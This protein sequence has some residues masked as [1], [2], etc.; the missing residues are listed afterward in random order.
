MQ[1]FRRKDLKR[2]R[3]VEEVG[4][5]VEYFS[6]H[7]KQFVGGGIAALVLLVG[8]VGY[9][10]YARQRGIDS[11]AALLKATTLY[12]G[13]V[14][15]ETVPGVTT[16][17]TEAER[18]EEVTRALDKVTLD[19]AGTAAATGAAYYSGLLDREQG[20]AVEAK[21]HFETA[22][23]GKGSEYPALARLALGGMLLAEGDVEA[24]REHFQAI[25][26]NP[27]RAVPKDRASIEVA[28]TLLQSDPQRARDMLS[29]IQA[30]NSPASPLAADLMETLGEGS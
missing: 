4:E 17:A 12:G 15:T 22:V 2:D 26:D 21:A 5:R 28:R 19:Y 30:A 3:F 9:G 13:V 14:T 10:G 18:V 20:N 29:E 8:G 27:T 1:R 23:R 6:S 11:Q 24:A 16:F 7:R 25:V